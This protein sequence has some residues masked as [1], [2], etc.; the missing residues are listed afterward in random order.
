MLVHLSGPQADYAGGG[1]GFWAAAAEQDEAP[2]LVLR[3]EPGSALVFGGQLKHA[4]VPVQ[5][6][7]RVVFV[8]SFTV[9]GAPRP[10]DGQK[11]YLES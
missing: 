4:G 8:A 5:S 1:T 6:G 11:E 2:S 7:T 9:R 10:V 3:P